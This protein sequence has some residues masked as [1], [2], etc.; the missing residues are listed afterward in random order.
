MKKCVSYEVAKDIMGKNF[1]GP[2]ELGAIKEFCLDI[3][4]NVYEIP[5]DEITL[6]KNSEDYYLI[7]AASKF[8]NG[9]EVNIKNLKSIMG[10][11]PDLKSPC[12]YFQDWYDNE[13]FIKAPIKEGWFFIKKKV[14]E[15]SRAVQPDD[16]LRQYSF[17]TAISCTYAFFVAW[18]TMNERLWLYDF[19]WCS[20]KDH[21][22]DR[23]YVGKYHDIDG[24]NRDGFS[25]HR[26]LALRKCY[27]CVDSLN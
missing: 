22:G 13:D 21:N 6:R 19:V 20:D 11:N 4:N 1:I 17:P 26:H 18:L 16:L 7:Y 25:I 5:F 23:I 9:D 27:A 15:D 12:F 2:D 3:P 14:Y 8:K 24:I 10:M